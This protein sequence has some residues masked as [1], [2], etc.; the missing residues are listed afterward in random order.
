MLLESKRHRLRLF[1]F[2]RLR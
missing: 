2:L 1:V